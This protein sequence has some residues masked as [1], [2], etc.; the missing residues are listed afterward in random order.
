MAVLAF[1]LFFVLLAFGAF[2]L[3][4]SGGP[5]GARQRIQTQSRRGRRGATALFVLA[6]LVLG[7]IVPAAVIATDKNETSIPEANVKELTP[8]Q[9]RGRELFAQRCRNCHTLKAA[10]ATA[11]VGPSLDEPPRNKSL[12]LGAI[13]EGRAN[14]NGNMPRAVYEGED[15]E[16][17]AEF[18]AVASGGE[19]K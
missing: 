12:V 18:V 9:E 16:A 4:M 13:A 1:V 19:L 8:L 3:G 17:V 15:A 14:G 10:N 5:R 11:K 2:F 6:I 7:I